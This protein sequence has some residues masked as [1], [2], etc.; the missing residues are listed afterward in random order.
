MLLF[1]LPMDGL[2]EQKYVGLMSI[3]V[4]LMKKLKERYVKQMQRPNDLSDLSII[5]TN[6]ILNDDTKGGPCKSD[7]LVATSGVK[8]TLNQK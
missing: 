7:A 2:L 5:T 8:S 4:V 6:N 3:C 1:G